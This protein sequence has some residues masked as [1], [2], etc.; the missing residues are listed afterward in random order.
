MEL[1]FVRSRRYVDFPLTRFTL[2]LIILGQSLSNVGSAKPYHRILGGVVVRGP[3]EHFNSDDP[4]P[5]GA[6]G[7]GEAM[8]DDVAKQVLA[9]AARSKRSTPQNIFQQ[10]VDLGSRRKRN[11]IEQRI[12]L[13]GHRR[14]HKP[15]ALRSK[16]E[17][18][19]PLKVTISQSFIRIRN[20]LS[21]Q[22]LNQLD[23]GS[24]P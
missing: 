6:I 5:E 20:P 7:C 14:T 2:R 1:G 10:S 19:L 24:L 8:V 21:I 15:F 11:R 17:R 3:P 18:I 12:M 16:S 9:L 13:S 23:G 22:D 4:F